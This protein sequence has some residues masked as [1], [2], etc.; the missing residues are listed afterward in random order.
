[1]SRIKTMETIFKYDL[2]ITDS[3]E[4]NVPV[5]SEILCVQT[6]VGLPKLWVKCNPENITEKRKIIIHGTGHAISQEAKKYI[7]TF[8]V[9]DGGF[10]F[11]VFEGR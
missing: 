1:M 7:G 2:T 6:Q 10:V 5:D 4:I 8:Q 3:Q 11:H 9:N